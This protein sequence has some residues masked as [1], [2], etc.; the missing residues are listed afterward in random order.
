VVLNVEQ[1]S[2]PVVNMDLSGVSAGL[3]ALR[4]AQ[5]E[6]LVVRRIVKN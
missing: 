3:Y 4:I 1:N 2:D 5:G 6:R